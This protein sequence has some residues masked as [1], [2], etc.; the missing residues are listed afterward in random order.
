MIPGLGS[1]AATLPLQLGGLL[2]QPLGQAL[3]VIVAIAV[4]VLVGRIALKIAWRLVTIA[5]VVVGAL[6]VLS[7][8]GI[9]VL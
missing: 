2:G 7:F 3:A 5:A 4:V 8:F 6:L 9:N 1:T